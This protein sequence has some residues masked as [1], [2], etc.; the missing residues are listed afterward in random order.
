MDTSCGLI[1]HK[2]FQPMINKAISSLSENGIKTIKGFEAFRSKPYLD[3]AGVS[4]IGWGTIRYPNGVRVT[5][6]D[7][8]IT[9]KQ[10]DI[11]FLHDV[12]NFEKDVDALTIDS[13]T[14]NQFDML[15]SFTYNLGAGALRRSTLLKK[16]N[17]NPNDLS[18]KDEFTKWIYADGKPLKGLLNRRN[19][20][21]SI[22]FS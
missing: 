9:Q 1:S 22:Y 13:L 4:T 3:K 16:V 17:R 12:A 5:L 8:E 21:A 20:E 18:I 7:D 19:K 11:F 2:K 10:A 15:V 14:Q 6:K